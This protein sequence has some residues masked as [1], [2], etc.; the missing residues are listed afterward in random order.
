[1]SYEFSQQTIRIGFYTIIL[2][3]IIDCFAIVST[4]A[5]MNLFLEIKN[6]LCNL[7]MYALA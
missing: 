4:D 2:G 6:L 1:M 7:R 5:S 3:G